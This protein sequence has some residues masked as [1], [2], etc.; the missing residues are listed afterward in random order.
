MSRFYKVASDKR[1]HIPDAQRRKACNACGTIFIFGQTAS[2]YAEREKDRARGGKRKRRSSTAEDLEEGEVPPEEIQ[3]Q[4]PVITA[5]C[6][7]C[8]AKMSEPLPLT[9]KAEKRSSHTVGGQA[10]AQTQAQAQARVDSS[11]KASK[12]DS[13]EPSKALSSNLKSKQ[14]A[15]ARKHQSLHDM[16]AKKET[17]TPSIGSSTGLSLMDFLH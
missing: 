4:G 11:G 16:L 14:R 9:P 13:V 5:S 1:I 2:I 15:K 8:G 3:R 12:P 17:S 10:Q 7:L 6:C